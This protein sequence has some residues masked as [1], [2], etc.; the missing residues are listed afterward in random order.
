MNFF[1]NSNRLIQELTIYPT[2]FDSS[3]LDFKLKKY[4]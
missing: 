4:E 1:E 3:K 2:I